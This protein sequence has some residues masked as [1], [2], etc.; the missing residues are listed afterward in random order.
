MIDFTSEI[1][2]EAQRLLQSEYVIWLT[3]VSQDG[4]P[5]PRPVWFI[6]DGD[7]VL[8]YSRP[9]AAKLKH[10]ARNPNVALHFNS[11]YQANANIAVMTGP[12]LTASG[13]PAIEVAAYMQKYRQ[14][15]TD[16][17]MTPESFSKTYSVAIRIAPHKLRD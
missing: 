10:I 8:I 3:T 11:D 2:K 16:I 9:S 13:Q 15:I 4:T 6:W 12:A 1:G 5:Q 17:G 14:G 7:A